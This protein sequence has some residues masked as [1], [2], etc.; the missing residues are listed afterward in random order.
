LIRV[1]LEVR[2]PHYLL[3]HHQIILLRSID[4]FLA[5]DCSHAKL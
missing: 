2:R 5:L 3:R 4:S 1:G